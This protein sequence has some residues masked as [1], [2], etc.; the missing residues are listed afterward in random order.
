MCKQA[1]GEAWVKLRA[2][3]RPLQ[4]LSRAPALPGKQSDC[5]SQTPFPG[6]GCGEEPGL[7]AQDKTPVAQGVDELPRPRYPGVCEGLTA[8]PIGLNICLSN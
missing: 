8:G 4:P 2:L 3:G 5:Q 6:N 7:L 1:P